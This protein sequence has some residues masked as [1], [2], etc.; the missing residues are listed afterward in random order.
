LGVVMTPADQDAA[1]VKVAPSKLTRRQRSS[2]I[3]PIRRPVN[4]ATVN[5]AASWAAAS[6]RSATS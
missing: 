4:A 6:R 5:S 1:T 2:R 3:S